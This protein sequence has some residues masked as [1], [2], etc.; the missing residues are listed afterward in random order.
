MAQTIDDPLSAVKTLGHSLKQAGLSDVISSQL[1]RMLVSEHEETTQSG[2]TTLDIAVRPLGI[3]VRPD[4]LEL[5]QSLGEILSA[6]IISLA[7]PTAGELM[8]L[9]S[10]FKLI[11]RASRRII[12][13]SKYDTE[14]LLHLATFSKGAELEELVGALQVRSTVTVKWTA[15]DVH[16]ALLRLK[17]VR[18]ADGQRVELAAFENGRWIAL[19]V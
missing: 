19:G 9:Y 16:G 11:Y 5:V 15:D 10:T 14:V 3:L 1:A 18:R 8:A 7:Q 13:L 2:G 6:A 12:R 17:E 4:D